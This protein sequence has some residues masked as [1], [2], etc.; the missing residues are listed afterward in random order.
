[1]MDQWVNDLPMPTA[2][3]VVEER[4]AEKVYRKGQKPSVSYSTAGKM[5]SSIISSA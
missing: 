3:D 4:L 2:V 5:K 1:M